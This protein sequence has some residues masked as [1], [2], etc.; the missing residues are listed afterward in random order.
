[1]KS[2]LIPFVTMM[3]L[4][5]LLPTG[6][7]K[8]DGGD[9]YDQITSQH[10]KHAI[11]A[12]MFDTIPSYIGTRDNHE[13]KVISPKKK[14]L[15][16]MVQALRQLNGT[17]PFIKDLIYTVGAGN[18]PDFNY[19]TIHGKEINNAFIIYVPLIKDNKVDFILRYTYTEGGFSFGLISRQ[20]IDQYIDAGTFESESLAH[21]FAAI[22]ILNFYSFI[23]S[24]N[25]DKK[26]NDAVLNLSKKVKKPKGGRCEQII[27]FEW[28]GYGLISVNGTTQPGY[29]T[30]GTFEIRIPCSGGGSNTT[31]TITTNT[32]T[33]SV[34]YNGGG[35]GYIS[36]TSL[37]STLNLAVKAVLP[38]ISNDCLD[39]MDDFTKTTITGIAQTIYDP[40][41]GPESI[42]NLLTQIVVTK[43]NNS[44]SESSLDPFSFTVAVTQYEFGMDVRSSLQAELDKVDKIIIDVKSFAVNCPNFQCVY[45]YLYNSGNKLFCNKLYL[46]FAYDE[47]INVKISGFNQPGGAEGI[48]TYDNGGKNINIKI[49]K[50]TCNNP[51]SIAGTL[52]HESIHAALYKEA[53][54]KDPTITREDIIKTLRLN[55]KTTDYDH[56]VMAKKYVNLLAESL[57][58][59]DGN[60]FP[61]EYYMYLAWTG[62]Q[63]AGYQLGI[64]DDEFISQYVDEHNI[65]TNSTKTF[66]N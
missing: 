50:N 42:K 31:Q 18:M 17:E 21:D 38:A 4:L 49:N 20:K 37:T 65:L 6:C 25:I 24:S 36:P 44:S 9:Q 13:I 66:C 26:L 28:W 55:A 16:D 14:Q 60:R 53:K 12:P 56:E 19:A 15:E 23:T 27:V 2:T 47:N 51:L 34:T 39:K 35:G 7:R 57:R 22:N 58:E 43:C 46:N 33:S 61:V 63:N 41:G 1:M 62:I 54:L 5:F 32:D 29:A 45:D 10:Q 52:I 59:A 8:D 40:C 3:T 64:L 48:T 30:S 11:Y